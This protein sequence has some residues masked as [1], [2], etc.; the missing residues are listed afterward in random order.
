MSWFVLALI[1]VVSLSIAL[2]LQRVMMKDDDSDPISYSIVFQFLLSAVILLFTFCLGR[3]ELPQ[4]N[5]ELIVRILASTFLWTGFTVFSFKAFKELSAGEVVIL[6]SG[7][8][9]ISI[10]LGVLFLSES[11][12]LLMILGTALI[13]LSIFLVNNDKLNFASKRGVVFAILASICSGT[14]VVNDAVVL[15]SIEVFTYV[16]IGSLLPGILILLLYPG[17]TKTTLT[18]MTSP[19][20][21]AMFF[22]SFFYA[23]Q[24]LTYYLAYTNGA[25]ISKLTPIS[26]ASIILTVILGI[27]FLKENKHVLKKLIA[28]ILVTVGVLVLT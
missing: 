15:R 10:V 23:I 2:I 9:I 22:M 14:A 21:K 3:F 8:V 28:A 6:R 27:V 5:L 19:K 4:L 17:K 7:G 26:N 13:L 16:G 12:S 1:S 20:V 24:A 25:P 18:L 11:L